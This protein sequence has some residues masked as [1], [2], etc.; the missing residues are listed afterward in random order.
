ML[1][2]VDGNCYIASVIGFTTNILIILLSLRIHEN[3][4][5]TY[6]WIINIQAGIEA[7]ACISAAALKVVRLLPKATSGY[8]IFSQI[9]RIFFSK[10]LVHLN[11]QV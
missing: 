1:R 2:L 8:S 10:T 5:Q 7:T 11:Y 6:I 3:E 4:I 9:P